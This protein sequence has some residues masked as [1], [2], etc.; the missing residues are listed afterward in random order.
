MRV[1]SRVVGLLLVAGLAAS[2]GV[3]IRRGPS[4]SGAAAEPL[5]WPHPPFRPQIRFI[6]S[7]ARPAD[8][9]IRPSFW[10]RLFGTGRGGNRHGFV[11]PGGVAARGD[12]VYV[13]DPGAQTVWVVDALARRFQPIRNAGEQRLVSPVA[14][15]PGRSGQFYVADSYLVKVFVYGPDGKL[16]DSIAD[17]SFRRPAG[18]AYD[19][20]RDRLYVA[21]TAAHRV[22]IFA[23]D[24]RPLGTI[25]RRGTGSGEFNFPTH[26]AVDPE[27]MLHVTD[28]MGFRIQTF[29]EDGRFL[30]SF[31]HH[32]DGSGDFAAPKGVGV[33]S[34]GNVYVVDALF[35]SVQ[36]FDRSGKFLLGFGDRG[37]DPGQFW[38]PGGLFV[39][40]EDRIYVAD[41]YNQRIQ[42]FEYLADGGDG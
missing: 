22:W 20:A 37:T 11:R 24:G 2:C 17:S 23:G 28:A 39:D 10:M 26:L 42:I 18:L 6:G 16:V 36:I 1:L 32:G 19:V 40:A 15:V 7:V 3:G 41:S 13:A 38:L 12:T 27:G 21:D 31:G 5:V 30:G 35:D 8:L 33:D 25:G 4:E 9:G 34:D 14:V 29:A